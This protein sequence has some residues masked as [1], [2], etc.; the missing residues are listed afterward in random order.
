MTTTAETHTPSRGCYQRGCESPEC[1]DANYRYCKKLSIEHARGERRRHDATQVRTHIERLLAKKWWREEIARAADVSGKVVG[2][3]LDG[4]RTV[5]KRIAL[6]ILSIPVVETTRTERGERQEP[7]GSIRRLRALAVI[8]HTW[9]V[10]SEH[11]G[12]T[13]DRLGALARGITDGI[14][15]D[16]ARKITEAYR[17]L[18]TIPGA[19]KQI[20]T[21]ARNKGWHGPL[22]WDAIDDPNCQPETA[23][24]YEDAPKYERDPDRAREMVHLHLLGESI[25]SIA[26]KIDTTEKYVADQLPVALRQRTWRLKRELQEQRQG[27]QIAETPEAVAA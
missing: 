5:S 1:A 23:A 11:T 24:S 9:V 21:G 26:K 2:N 14:R 6:A 4:Q 10:V 20:A 8:G 17:R 19:S 18:S 22:A 16:E 25:P 3:I 7:T 12:M 27:D 15:P 13:G